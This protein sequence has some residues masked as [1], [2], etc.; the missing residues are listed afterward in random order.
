MWLFFVGDLYGFG[1]NDSHQLGLATTPAEEGDD[2]ESG[3]HI[4]VPTKIPEI[5]PI[6]QVSCGSH[7]TLAVTEELDLWGWGYG[8]RGQ[9]GS[10]DSQDVEEPEQIEIRGRKCLKVAAGGQHTILLIRKKDE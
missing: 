5:P 8:E 7:F 3:N 10:E 4:P 2:A 1:R 6:K 9:L